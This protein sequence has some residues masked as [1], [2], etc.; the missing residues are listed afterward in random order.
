MKKGPEKVAKLEKIGS[1]IGVGMIMLFFAGL[2]WLMPLTGED[3]HF[4][5]CE[6]G[7]CSSVTRIGETYQFL[8][9]KQMDYVAEV[10]GHLWWRAGA[11]AIAVSSFYLLTYLILGRRP[12][13]TKIKESGLLL[14]VFVITMMS[15][16]GENY[17]ARFDYLHNYVIGLII[18]GLFL[19]PFWRNWMGKAIKDKLWVSGLTFASGILIAPMAIG[20]LIIGNWLITSIKAQKIVWPPKYLLAGAAGL[21]VGLVWLYGGGGAI[22]HLNEE[23]YT[24]AF[25]YLSL[26]ALRENNLGMNIYLLSQHLHFNIA[27]IAWALPMM[28]IGCLMEWQ[29]SKKGQSGWLKIQINCLLFVLLNLGAVM[30]IAIPPHTYPRMMLMAY[31][32][33]IVNLGITVWRTI[34]AINWQTKRGEWILMGGLILLVGLLGADMTYGFNRH[35]RNIKR[36]LEMIKNSP[37]ETYCFDTAAT[38]RTVFTPSPVFAFYEYPTFETIATKYYDKTLIYADECA[39]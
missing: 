6:S 26:E 1:L 35:A 10:N 27:P 15:R 20:I 32:A 17:Y 28:A 34:E 30:Q 11:M 37:E 8:I 14:V 24:R 39:Q 9:A 3:I 23:G 4:R 29:R 22:S 7:E 33:I 13:L 19:I 5:Y 18:T 12:R 25:N 2:Y 21:V 16:Y 38:A 31:G 36:E